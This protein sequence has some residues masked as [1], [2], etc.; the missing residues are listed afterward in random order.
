MVQLRAFLGRRAGS[1]RMAPDPRGHH[2]ETQGIAIEVY[3]GTQGIAIEVYLGTQGIAIEV[4]L[5]IQGIAIEVSRLRC[6]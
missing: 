6:I 1:D 2:L 3:I 5:G 4:Y